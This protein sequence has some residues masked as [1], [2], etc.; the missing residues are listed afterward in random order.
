MVFVLLH[1]SR[2]AQAAKWV[3][4]LL[5][6]HPQLSCCLDATLYLSGGPP[7]PHSAAARGILL[8]EEAEA[9]TLAAV[10]QQLLPGGQLLLLAWRNPLNRALHWLQHES[11]QPPAVPPASA[12]SLLSLEE[13]L[14]RGNASDTRC[15]QLLSWLSS[16]RPAKRSHSKRST[17]AER[18]RLRHDRRL[19]GHEAPSAH[20]QKLSST[21]RHLRERQEGGGR[22]VAREAARLGAHVVFVEQLLQDMH[23]TL[24]AAAA[25]AVG[26][27]ADPAPFPAPSLESVELID[28]WRH[29][30][31]A[32]GRAPAARP[33]SHFVGGVDTTA[34]PMGQF[35]QALHRAARFL[36]MRASRHG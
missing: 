8:E 13:S 6:L 2:D 28:A 36:P 31:G 24:S 14:A 20:R 29:A 1:A 34:L 4:G 10:R 25:A 15:A 32:A 35:Y 11:F 22:T 5:G 9:H 27:D 26:L 16:A 21:T 19:K 12:V 17:P 30:V 33:S 7:P 23:G 3:S 18:A